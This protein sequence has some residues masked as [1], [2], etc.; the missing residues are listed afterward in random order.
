MAS[1]AWRAA[2]LW[3]RADLR[4]R[5]LSLVALGI[6]AG[7][8]GGVALASVSGAL[9]TDSA[10]DRLNQRTNASDAVVFPSQVGA[11]H[12]DWSTFEQ[13]PEIASLE[14][15]AIVFGDLEGEPEAAIFVPLDDW[16]Q[17]MDAPIVVDGRMWDPEADDEIVVADGFARAEGIEV[18]DTVAFSPYPPQPVAEGPTDEE[19]AAGPAGLDLDLKVVGIVRTPL[20]PLFV[21]DG[22]NIAA[23]GVI[24]RH[25]GVVDYIENGYV[26]LRDPVADMADLEAHATSDLAEGAP[27][28]DLH[29]SARRVTASTDVERT[30]LLLLAA[31][32]TVAGLVLAGQVAGRSASRI[33]TDARVLQAVGMRRASVAGA[34]ALAHVT[35]SVVALG[36]CVATAVVT[37]RWLPLGQASR[38]EPD[39]GMRLD[40]ALVLPGAVLVAVLLLASTFATGWLVAGAPRAADVG[41]L[42]G[43]VE[44]LRRH[45][46]PPVGIGATLA[47]RKGRGRNSVAV[48]PALAG[49]AVGV[50]GVAAALTLGAGLQGALDHPERAGSVWDASVATND[51]EVSLHTSFRKDFV[52]AVSGLDEIAAT[53]QVDRV[54]VQVNGATG[55][56]TFSTRPIDDQGRS[57]IQLATLDGRGPERVGEAALGPASAKTLGVEVGDTVEIGAEGREVEVVGTALFPV[58]VHAQFDEGIWL[59][60]DDLDAVAPLDEDAGRY[61][62]TEFRDGVS[63][64]EGV[65]ALQAAA[66]PFGGYSVGREV[67]PEL[68]NLR[69]VRSLPT[70]LAGFLAAFAVAALLHVLVTTSRVRAGEFAVLRAIGFTRRGTRR[71]IHVQAA[72]VFVVGLAVGIPLGL[73]LGRTGWGLIAER[74]PL[75]VVT[76]MALVATA[77]LVPVG[78]MIAQVLSLAPARRAVRRSP[79]EVLRSE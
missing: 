1:G 48:R 25:L 54:A 10:L 39:P 56:P 33:Q 67:P 71:I 3:A 21:G 7:V 50:L 9:R 51:Q 31:A 41:A 42:P 36:T 77:L 37:S 49:A 17:D 34:T 27:I 20:E 14:V 26:Q 28:L 30:A 19:D 45:A 13:R 47:L 15:W 2:R 11:F 43:L 74:V 18:G 24:D 57:P 53:A 64:E 61:L 75:E 63:D 73:A 62:V 69:G 68:A 35:S 66:E 46:S 59:F 60:P 22:F 38:V 52:D 6:I 72:V 79:A 78:L 44:W 5:W 40:A 23:P 12:P 29:D 65:A 8:T 76:P 32:V 16:A 58:D 55:L 70:V 4:A